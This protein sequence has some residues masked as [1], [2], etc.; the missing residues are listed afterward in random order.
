MLHR[1]TCSSSGRRVLGIRDRDLV[2]MGVVE[3]GQSLFQIE[4]RTIEHPKYELTDRIL[5]KRPRLDQPRSLELLRIAD[6]GREKQIE[7]CSILELG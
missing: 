5:I 7:W 3:D 1:R 4:R 2:D 6:I